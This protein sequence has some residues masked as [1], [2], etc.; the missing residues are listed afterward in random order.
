[1][2]DCVWAFS[3]GATFELAMSDLAFDWL[4]EC[5]RHRCVVAVTVLV[6]LTVV[7]LFFSSL[8]YM[9]WQEAVIE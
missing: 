7:L 4:G 1:M 3:L 6:A 9:P 5:E 2:N 8:R